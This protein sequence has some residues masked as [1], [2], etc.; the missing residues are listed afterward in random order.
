[1]KKELGEEY[2]IVKMR[3]DQLN[4]EYERSTTDQQ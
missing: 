4:E 3:M 2:E 1:M